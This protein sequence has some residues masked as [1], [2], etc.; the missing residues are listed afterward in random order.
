MANG[1]T[2]G[3]ISIVSSQAKT[4]M[5]H[6]ALHW[7]EVEDAPLWPLAVQ[8]TVCLHNHAPNIDSCVAP[9]EVYTCTINDCQA[10]HNAH[11]W[12]CPIYILESRLSTSADQNSLLGSS[13]LSSTMCWSFSCAC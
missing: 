4:S 1:V 6:S 5:I 8:N 11:P 13:V 7:P 9:I 12:G 10:L 2:E 3:A